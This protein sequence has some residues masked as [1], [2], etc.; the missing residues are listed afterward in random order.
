MTGVTSPLA[1]CPPDRGRTLLMGYDPSGVFAGFDLRRHLSFTPGSVSVQTSR[2]ALNEAL[3]AG[4]AVHDKGQGE[5]AFGVRPDL[6]MTYALNAAELHAAGANARLVALLARAAAESEIPTAELN[7]LSAERRR[8]VATVS[9]NVRDR[10]FRKQ[11]L[12]AYD[13]RCAVTRMQLDLVEA[14]HIL[15]VA[16]SGSTDVVQNGICLS[17]TFHAAYD[18]GLIYLDDQYAMQL[19]AARASELQQRDR[20]AGLE[21]IR[22]ALGRIHLPPNSA[23]WPNQDFIRRPNRARRIETS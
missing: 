3:Q 9:R 20:L 11:V 19:N 14:A 2:L 6:F 16:E 18:S 7:S 12:Q 13:Y 17:P 23:W 21:W 22:D 15:A 8:I 4:F 5:V 10:R 1:Q